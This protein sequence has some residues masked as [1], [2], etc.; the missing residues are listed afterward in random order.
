MLSIAL[1]A[2][3]AAILA[4]GCLNPGNQVNRRSEGYRRIE[5]YAADGEHVPF[6]CKIGIHSWKTYEAR[7]P[8]AIEIELDTMYECICG[9][10]CLV[11]KT[12]D[13]ER[14]LKIS[15]FDR[16]SCCM[17]RDLPTRNDTLFCQL[18][19]WSCH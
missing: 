7:T 15:G 9:T 16:D 19:S 1:C 8:W 11:A 3:T 5:V 18:R 14:S 2:L 6:V 4:A 13:D 17:R 12:T 10:H